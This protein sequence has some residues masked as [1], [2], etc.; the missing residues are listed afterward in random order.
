M[1]SELNTAIQYMAKR[2]IGALISI[3]QGNSLEEF[4]NTGIPIH[5]DIPN[6]LITNILFQTHRFTMGQ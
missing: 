1:I 6:Q 3:E 5:S 2:R 4:I